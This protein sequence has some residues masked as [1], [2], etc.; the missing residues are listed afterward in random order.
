MAN[1]PPTSMRLR[2]GG[3]EA[4]DMGV[5]RFRGPR[6]S[7][8]TNSDTSEEKALRKIAKLSRTHPDL[9]ERFANVVKKASHSK[10]PHQQALSEIYKIVSNKIAIEW[11]RKKGLL[12]PPT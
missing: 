4:K 2:F 12:K 11:L 9:K 8:S 10:Y 3:L 6:A 1:D 5:T 7:S